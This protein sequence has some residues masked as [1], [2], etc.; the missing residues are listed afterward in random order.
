MTNVALIINY[1]ML[2][3]LLSSVLAI[4]FFTD[5]LVVTFLL[6]IFSLV[7]AVAYLVMDAPDVAI[8][9]AAVGAG[10]STLVLL[11]AISL[12]ER[13]ES[14]SSC[15]KPCNKILA[16]ICV[17]P[18]LIGLFYAIQDMVAFGQVISPVH[19]HISA[20][21]IEATKEFMGFTN[22]VTAILASFRGYD[23][24]GETTVVLIAAISVM[25][26]IGDKNEKNT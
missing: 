6:S 18:M 7:M 24:L 4:I 15:K 3:F 11:A 19:N 21:Y 13:Y 26:L 20:Y 2:L 9:E 16:V 1:S 8:T 25:L 10:I 5:L 23:T 22:I 14:K 17:V 12:T